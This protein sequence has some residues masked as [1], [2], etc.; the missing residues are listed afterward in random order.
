MNAVT[1]NIPFHLN[2]PTLIAAMCHIIVREDFAIPPRWSKAE[3]RRRIRETLKY[4]G[5]E[6]S[7]SW[8]DN[9]DDPHEVDRVEIWATRY[10]DQVWP[11]LV[12][13]DRRTEEG[14]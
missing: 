8:A 7:D 2:R 4:S 6:V 10:V 13:S 9:V 11:E 1:L 12:S 5:V 14:R 3:I